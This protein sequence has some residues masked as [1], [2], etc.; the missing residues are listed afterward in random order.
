[1][2]RIRR[3]AYTSPPESEYPDM[4][5]EPTTATTADPTLAPTNPFDGVG[6]DQVLKCADPQTGWQWFDDREGGQ[7]IKYHER[8]GY[9]PMPTAAT[10]VAETVSL[11]RVASY[12]VSEVYLEVYAGESA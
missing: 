2:N 8:D 3:F 10:V 6:A 12:S 7:I 5:I 1:M 9:A 4:S 11:K